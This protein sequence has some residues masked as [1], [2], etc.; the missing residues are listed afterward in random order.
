MKCAKTQT[1]SE[2]YF[3]FF[4]P[5]RYYFNFVARNRPS[6]WVCVLKKNEKGDDVAKITK[7]NNAHRRLDKNNLL[8]KGFSP[9]CSI[10]LFLAM[11]TFGPVLNIDSELGTLHAFRKAQR[12][13]GVVLVKQFHFVRFA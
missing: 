6:R 12:I 4:L 8:L 7:Y 2:V 9:V 1:R 5:L 10:C 11:T 13:L 3:D